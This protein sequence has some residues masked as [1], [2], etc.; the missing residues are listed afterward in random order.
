MTEWWVENEPRVDEVLD[1][2]T[3]GLHGIEHRYLYH[4]AWRNIA[5]EVNT[6]LLDKG[7]FVDLETLENGAINV[8]WKNSLHLQSNV[9]DL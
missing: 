7:Y 8:F 9:F 5:G 6:Y 2:L 3:P 4:W 1:E